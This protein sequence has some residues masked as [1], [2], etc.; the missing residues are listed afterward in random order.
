[1]KTSSR[2]GFTLIELLVTISIIGILA[3]LLLPSLSQAKSKA[4]GTSC[5][6]NLRQIGLGLEMYCQDNNSHLPT[7]SQ[8][9]SLG[10]NQASF[11]KTLASYAGN[12][13]V[14]QCPADK[15]YFPRERTSYEWNTFLNGASYDRPQE[16][17]PVTQSIVETVFGGR[18]NT[19]LSGDCAPFHGERGV[20]TGKNALYFEGRV[21]KSRKK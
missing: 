12:P 17:S 7:C 20:W 5:I 3:G 4:L 9:P 16:W 10:T 19:P 2:N 14:F 8:L 15:K 6:S 13:Q 1:M 18:L 11:P 21:E